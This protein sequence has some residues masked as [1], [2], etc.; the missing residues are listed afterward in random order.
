MTENEFVLCSILLIKK[1]EGK[2]WGEVF[3]ECW[4]RDSFILVSF[5]SFRI[6]FRFDCVELNICGNCVVRLGL[7]GRI[8]VYKENDGGIELNHKEFLEYFNLSSEDIV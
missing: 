3:P 8:I 6:L 7:N 1:Y 5:K 2:L 4:V